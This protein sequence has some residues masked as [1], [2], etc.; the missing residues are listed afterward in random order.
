M[1]NE[2]RVS[3]YMAFLL[4]HDPKGMQ[5]SEQGFVSLSDLLKVLRERFP[6]IDAPYVRQ[7]VRHDVRGRYQI[8]DD[9]IRARYGHSID[10]KP[11]FPPAEVDR[12]YHGTSEA[13]AEQILRDGMRPMGRQRV[14]LSVNMDDAIGVGKRRAFQPVV[15]EIDARQ[16]IQEG[17]RIEK[18]S[19]RICVTDY[20]PPRF[21]KRPD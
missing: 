6:W 1:R 15:L 7:V 4:R 9:G 17:I 20:V 3:K 14:H 8:V 16:A 10:V 18:A 11:Q 13:A 21:I 19:D 12:L 5:I 2:V